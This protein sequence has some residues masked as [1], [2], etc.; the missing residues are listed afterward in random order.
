VPD[1][2]NAKYSIVITFL[3]DAGDG[4]ELF[5]YIDATD[6][7]SITFIEYLHGRMC[8]IKE[9][10]FRFAKFKINFQAEKPDY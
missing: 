5:V 7:L 3:T 4:Y 1:S 6:T 8:T 10:Y 9:K 2:S